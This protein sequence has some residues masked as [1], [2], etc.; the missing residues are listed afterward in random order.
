[1]DAFT[2]YVDKGANVE[3][4]GS[5]EKPFHDISDAITRAQELLSSASRPVC[6]FLAP[7]YYQELF[8]V[9]IP[10]YVNVRG[11]D[12]DSVIVHTETGASPGFDLEDDASISSLSIQGP[13]A[14]SCVRANGTSRCYA[15]NIHCLSGQSAFESVAGDL[16]VNRGRTRQGVTYGLHTSGGGTITA[17]NAIL[18]ENYAALR[19][20]SSG[21]LIRGSAVR[22]IDSLVYD[23][24]QEHA[25]AVVELDGGR[26]DE[27]KVSVA[28][29]WANISINRYTPS[30]WNDYRFSDN[31]R[32]AAANQPTLI[33]YKD[34]GVYGFDANDYVVFDGEMPHRYKEG[35]DFR[36]HIHWTPHSRG[37]TEDEKTVA[38]KV[39]LSIANINGTFPDSTTYDL[40]DTCDGVNDK[41]QKFLGTMIDGTGVTKSALILGRVYRDSGDSWTGTGANSPALLEADLHYQSDYPGSREELIK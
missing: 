20:E 8:T 15:N 10:S 39:K 25:S 35:S 33:A 34:S 24:L 23:I 1:M 30:Y 6:V 4:H 7:G 27:D 36:I 41:H 2:I 5:P 9:T 18:V 3:L 12:T 16:T 31:F 37:V 22:A 29:T 40:T 14:A 38:W 19:L 21:D 28:S 11:R 26:Y 13:L 17:H 32:L